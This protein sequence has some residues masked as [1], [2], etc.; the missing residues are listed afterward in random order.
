M[1]CISIARKCKASY[2]NVKV[3]ASEC[4]VSLKHFISERKFSQGKHK[5]DE[6][7]AGFLGEIR[8]IASK[9]KVSQET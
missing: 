8:S 9:C 7:T 2:R 4:N 1:L 5:F 6:R 3:F